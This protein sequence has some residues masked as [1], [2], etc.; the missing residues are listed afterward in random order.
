VQNPENQRNTSTIFFAFRLKK[1]L[2]LLAVIYGF[3]S[4]AILA[5]EDDLIS[6]YRLAEKA[7]PT[8][9]QA[10]ANYLAEKQRYRQARGRLMPNINASANVGRN[11][12][13][14][15]LWARKYESRGY[16][17]SLKQ[18]LIDI[19]LFAGFSESKAQ[20][21]RA[22][23]IFLAAKHNLILRTI[24]QYFDVLLAYDGVTQAE[25]ATK[26]IRQQLRVAQDRLDAGLGTATDVYDARARF[27]IARTETLEVQSQLNDTI[28]ALYGITGQRQNLLKRLI[29]DIPAIKPDPSDEQEWVDQALEQNFELIAAEEEVIVA[30]KQLLSAQSRHFP[31]LNLVGAHRKSD[32]VNSSTGLDERLRDTS[33]GVEMTVPIFQGGALFAGDEEA[34]Q[35]YNAALQNAEKIRR[36]TERKA[37]SAYEGTVSGIERNRALRHAVVASESALDSKQAAY[38]AGI[39]TNLDVLNA[40]R[41]LYRT[42]RDYAR[43][44][45]NY[46]LSMVSLKLAAG[47]LSD[48]DLL[49]INELLE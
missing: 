43:A 34:R 28:E 13:E 19:G 36:A 12:F 49:Y 40:Q 25:A 41:D 33:I 14:S 7:D 20:G 27:E 18:P 37:R 48:E 44:R 11:D 39:E 15:N 8:Y 47:I 42:K 31:I 6:V 3:W 35:R 23:A 45:Y 46:L 26:A 22:R 5:G 38:E 32:S 21:R 17:L 10:Q 29:P 4:S 24:Q 1:P 2:L 9:L 30:K 16:S